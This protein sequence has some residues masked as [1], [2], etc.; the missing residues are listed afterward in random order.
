MTLADYTVI[1]A[2][3]HVGRVREDQPMTADRMVDW[4]DENDVDR[5]VLLP[6]ESPEATSYYVPTSRT[7]DLAA[8]HP[9]RF[10]PFCSVDPRMNVTG[11]RDAFVERIRGYVERG[12]R[13]FGEL[14]AGLPIDHDLMQTLYGIAGEFD[15]PVLLHIETTVCSDEVGLPGFESMLRAFPDTDFIAHAPGWWAHVS[16]DVDRLSGYPDGPVEPGGRCDELLSGYDNC[17]AD[18]SAG[19]GWNA[20]TRDHEYGQAFLERHHE[21]LLWAT[22]YLAPGQETPQL[23]VLETFDLTDEMAENLFHRTVERV[24]R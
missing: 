5:V 13:G 22:D 11:G 12:A 14:K 7:L 23:D 20:L 19:S 16:A 18:L 8:A 10:I 17:Y 24:L 6:L 21:S 1:D 4:M 15:L 2:H 9:E 3:T